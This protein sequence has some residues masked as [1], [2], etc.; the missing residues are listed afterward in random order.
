MLLPTGA[1]D[2]RM[3]TNK[4]QTLV[5]F[6]FYSLC[7]GQS[8]AGPYGY[9]PLP[10]NLVQAGFEQVSKLG[11]ADS[12]VDISNRDATKCNNPTFVA[13][14][15]NRN[16]LAEVAPA[17]AACDKSGAGPCLTA[18]QTSSAGGAAAGGA[19]AAGGTGGKT[20]TGTTGGAGTTDA[21]GATDG[22]DTSAFAG[23]VDPETGLPTSDGNGTSTTASASV[24]TALPPQPVGSSILFGALSAVE[25]LALVLLPA[26][27]VVRARRKRAG[28]V[29]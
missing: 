24:A 18:G 3:S 4:R 11:A 15:L 6:M 7:E 16:K 17:P 8:K 28:G 26:F 2:A 29:L 9:S 23:T 1:N 21:N 19:G 25:L 14:D 13:G 10:L 27:F 12:G 5:D 22:T 20:T